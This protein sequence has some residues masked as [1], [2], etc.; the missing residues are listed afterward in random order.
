MIVCLG[1]GSLIWDP[2]SLDISGGWEMNGPEVPV[3]YL[4]QSNKDRM[5]LVIEPSVPKQTVLWAKMETKDLIGAKES[6]R[7]REGKTKHEY[8]GTWSRRDENLLR[9]VWNN[10]YS[11]DKEKSLALI[12]KIENIGIEPY[13]APDPL[14]LIDKDEIHLICWLA[15]QSEA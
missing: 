6:L 11:S 13:Q 1:W 2:G 9:I 10:E 7:I 5:T 4:R 3:E 12:K 14:P 8:I 15:I